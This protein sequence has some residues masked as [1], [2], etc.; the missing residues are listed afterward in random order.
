MTSAPRRPSPIS[1]SSAQLRQW[2]THVLRTDADLDA[3]CCDYFPAVHRR[4]SDGMERQRKLTL[5]LGCADAAEIAACLCRHAPEVVQSDLGVE[6]GRGEIPQVLPQRWNRAAW[7]GGVALVMTVGVSIG[8]AVR[9]GATRQRA[10][11][12]TDSSEA[13]PVPRTHTVPAQAASAMGSALLTSD[14][15]GAVVIEP[16]SGRVLGQ[17]PWDPTLHWVDGY[18]ARADLRVCLRRAGYFP[19]LVKLDLASGSGGFRP[20]HAQ[21]QQKLRA[22]D[23]RELGQGQEACNETTIIIP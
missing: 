4:F 2:L 3:F 8:L 23:Q 22:A 6:D 7:L 14:P 16:S 11:K 17:T 21:L 13:M 12:A 10:L 1:P 5:L 9:A 15:P 20:V 18:S 19:A